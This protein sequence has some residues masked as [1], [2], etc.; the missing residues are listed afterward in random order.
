MLN[1]NAFF[2]ENMNGAKPKRSVLLPPMP[3]AA[4]QDV[5]A[6]AML[7]RSSTRQ[8]RD[9]PEEAPAEMGGVA[10]GSRGGAVSSVDDAA[11]FFAGTR[12]APLAYDAAGSAAA[13][14]GRTACTSASGGRARGAHDAENIHTGKIDSAVVCPQGGSD[15]N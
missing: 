8:K 11:V 13:A 7:E 4:K 10:G 15:R 14:S 9:A 3:V 1:Q 2:L 5:F 6:E 12:Y